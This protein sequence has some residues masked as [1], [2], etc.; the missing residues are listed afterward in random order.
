[1]ARSYEEKISN[2]DLEIEQLKN[3]KHEITQRHK[4]EDL[5][6]VLLHIEVV[7]KSKMRM[8][9]LFTIIQENEGLFT[10]RFCFRHRLRQ[11]TIIEVLCGMQ[12]K[13]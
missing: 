13:K 5:L 11:N 1:M 6:S 8:T 12:L 10:H 4:A 2:I 9:V 7:K 3:R